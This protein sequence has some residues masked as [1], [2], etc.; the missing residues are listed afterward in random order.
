M[1]ALGR[2]MAIPLRRNG[3]LIGI[4]VLANKDKKKYSRKEANLVETVANQAAIAL[5][6]AEKYQ[7][8]KKKSEID[9]LT[10]LYNYRSFEH[11]LFKQVDLA[12]LG[13]RTLTLILLDIDHFKK[14][15]DTYGHLAGNKIL[16][17][18]SQIL[19]DEIEEVGIVARYGGEEFTIL[20]SETCDKRGYHRAEQLRKRIESTEF[21]VEMDLAEDGSK[22]QSKKISVTASVGLATYPL[23]AEDALSLIR[24]ADRAMYLGAKRNGRNKVAVYDAG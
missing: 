5:K 6:N 23:H 21:E 2:M 14:V 15:N 4:L 11:E 16:R 18:I 9:E 24:H 8:Q 3:Q 1:R 17:E 10:G 7:N 20:L 19:V 22:N 13:E 12:R